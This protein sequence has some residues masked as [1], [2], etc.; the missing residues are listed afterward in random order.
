MQTLPL[1][2]RHM[3]VVAP[4]DLRQASSNLQLEVMRSKMPR[5]EG[6]QLE[7][8]PRLLSRICELWLKLLLRSMLQ[9]Q[10]ESICWRMPRSKQA[11]L[12]VMY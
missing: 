8:V 4:V 10:L 5:P 9:L 6:L 11:Q 1:H 7:V 3:E 12:E 2:I